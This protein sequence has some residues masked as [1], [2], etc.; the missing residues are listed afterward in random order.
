MTKDL[1]PS[2]QVRQIN[3]TRS[4][5]PNQN[6]KSP[7]DPESSTTSKK[8]LSPIVVVFDRLIRKIKFSW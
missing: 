7:A 5:E 3:T 4:V 8:V 2:P 1:T 6:F